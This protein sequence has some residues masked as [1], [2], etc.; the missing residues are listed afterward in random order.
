MAL[1]LTAAIGMA[2][3]GGEFCEIPQEGMLLGKPPG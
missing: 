2:P 3:E 1:L